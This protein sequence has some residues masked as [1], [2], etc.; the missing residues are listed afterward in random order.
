MNRHD[1]F[2]MM[3]MVWLM[4]GGNVEWILLMVDCGLIVCGGGG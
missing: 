1:G 3:M 4:S 2:G